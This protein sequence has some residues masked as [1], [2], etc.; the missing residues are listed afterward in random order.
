MFSVALRR[1]VL[2][3]FAALASAVPLFRPGS[4]LPGAS[5]PLLGAPPPGQCAAFPTPRRALRQTLKA[6]VAEGMVT[7]VF[8]A[9]AGATALTAWAIALKLGPFLVGVMTALPFFAQFIQF[10]AAWLTST[11]GHRRVALTAVFLSRVVMLPLCAVPWLPLELAGQ[12]RLLV[13]IAAASA[14]LGVVGNNA[15]VAWMG[16]LVPG[17]LRG[18]Y[19]GRRTALC[20]LSGTLA[21]LTA[22]FLLDRLRG[23]EGPGMGLPLLA[24]FACAVGFITTYIMSL[25]HDPS[26]GGTPFRL[27][28]RATLM[29][30]KDGRARRVLLYQVVWNAA[31]GLSAPYF[32]FHTIQNLQ[33]SFVFMA[34]H[35]AAVA[36]VRVLTAPLWGKLIDRVGAQPVVMACSLGISTIPLLWLLPDAGTLWPLAFDALLA[37]GLWSGHGLAVFAL[38]LAVAPRQGRPFYLAAFATTGGLAYAAASAVGGALAGALPA[39]F[40]LGNHAWVNFHVLFVLSAFARF[41]AVFFAARIVEPEAHSVTSIGALLGMLKVR[42]RT[43]RSL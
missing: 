29:P 43:V 31:V 33:M 18:R 2:R 38:P 36:G 25:Q 10:P 21:S 42:P 20:T 16:E 26:P 14:V 4:S 3:S 28:L 19:F 35:A 11:F 27:D 9:C 1:H 37:G 40:T 13:G 24:G 22:G 32:A 6:S 39:T 17:S 30:W 12:Q 7:E 34:L 8:T 23:T 5:A 41:G 15:W